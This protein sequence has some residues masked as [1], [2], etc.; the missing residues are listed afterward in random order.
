[1]AKYGD[2]DVDIED[3]PEIGY[4]SSLFHSHTCRA[5]GFTELIDVSLVAL[6]VWCPNNMFSQALDFQ[7]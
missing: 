3:A 7:G 2:K 6:L 5:G 4:R 1:M